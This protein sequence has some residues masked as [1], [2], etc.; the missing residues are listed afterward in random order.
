MRMKNTGCHPP[1]GQSEDSI[2]LRM[3]PEEHPVREALKVLLKGVSQ[4]ERKQ[5]LSE[6]LSY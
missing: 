1:A 3:Q 5:S 6:Q 4:A 2:L